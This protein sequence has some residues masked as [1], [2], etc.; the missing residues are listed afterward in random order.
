MTH[1]VNYQLQVIDQKST[2]TI[3]DS[4]VTPEPFL[5][6]VTLEALRKRQ[7]TLVKQS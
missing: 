1:A 5:D 3:F 7:Q 6:S 2:V 4:S